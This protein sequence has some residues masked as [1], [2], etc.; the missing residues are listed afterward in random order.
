MRAADGGRRHR[1]AAVGLAHHGA[2]VAA[3]PATPAD[4]RA[5]TVSGPSPAA[6]VVQ[7]G[8]RTVTFRPRVSDGP[9][10]TQAARGVRG[11]SGAIAAARHLA[12][13]LVYAVPAVVLWWHAWDGH[14]GSTLACTCGDSGQQVWFIAWPA[15]ALSHGL[16]A[17][18]S[19]FVQAPHGVNLLDNASGLPVGLVLAPLTWLAGPIVSTNVALTLCPALSAWACWVACRRLVS[20]SP[21]AL[22]A[23][24]LFGYSPFVVTNDTVGHVGL[25][26]LVVPPLLLVAYREVLC[27]R[28]ERRVRWGAAAGALVALQFFLS[29]EVLAILAVVGTPVAA[30]SVLLVPRSRRASAVELARAG[31]AAVAVCALLV[32]GPLWL[33]LFGPDHLVGPP[34]PSAY[35]SGNALPSFVSAGSYRAPAT[36]LLRLGGYLGALGPPSAY[37]GPA[38]LVVVV[39]GVAAAWRRRAVKALV[40]AALLSGLL[41]LGAVLVLGPSDMRS[42]WLPWR[43]VGTW[44]LLDGIIPQRFSLVLDLCAAI[45]FGIALDTGRRLLRAKFPTRQIGAD[46]RRKIASASMVAIAVMAVVSLWWTYQ[47]PL[48]TT[49]VSVPRWFQ[50]TAD[51][52]RTGSTLLV[53]PFAFPD[54]GVSA[55]MVWQASSGMA[56]HLAGGYIKAPAPDGRPLSDAPTASPY[57][58][59][60][61]LSS[62]YAG[63]L[64]AP[65]PAVAASLRADLREWR[66]D[67][68]VIARGGRAP[69][70]ARALFSEAIGHQPR[71]EHG[72]WVW[73]LVGRFTVPRGAR[74][75]VGSSR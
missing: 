49:S 32:A 59:L 56:F 33:S 47:V 38:V 53:Y 42:A 15:Y 60:A 34:W 52:I 8:L 72:C 19:S 36:T 13:V 61:R 16:D 62:A 12:V 18:I 48:R 44:P 9:R 43:V 71:R 20:W 31:G 51:E 23:G 1:Q 35:V 26:L 75:R 27:G 46:A 29:S 74:M 6:P 73:H 25:S 14:L 67:D 21:A 3:T 2:H 57:G 28:P 55:P 45:L 7:R 40:A 69:N 4:R 63:S 50:L 41:S 22:A 24:A 17:L 54:D 37:L 11:R 39:A 5:M 64:P 30:M 10:L 58:M 68:V 65:T 66:V 70:E